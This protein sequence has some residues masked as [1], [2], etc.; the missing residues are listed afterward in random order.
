MSGGVGVAIGERGGG[1]VGKGTLGMTTLVWRVTWSTRVGVAAAMRHVS[2]LLLGAV[3][4]VCS[5]N[6]GGYFSLCIG[7]C[8]CDV[9]V[10]VFFRR[11]VCR[12]NCNG[13]G[14]ASVSR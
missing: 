4:V 5:F 11:V 12:R 8:R 9:V 1:L 2:W 6:R 10:G 7:G 3:L 13:S 14:S